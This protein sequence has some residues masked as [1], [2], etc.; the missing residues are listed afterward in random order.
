MNQRE[1]TRPVS[2]KTPQV[3]V[4]I[5]CFN[6]RSYLD[7]CLNSLLASD[8]SGLDR[9]LLVV[10]DGSTDGSADYVKEHFPGVYCIRTDPPNRGFAGVNNFGWDYIQEN[11]PGAEFVVLLNVDTIVESGWLT[12]LVDYLGEHPAVGSV[13]AKLRLHPQSETLNTAGNRCHFL[14]F[15]F[16]VGYGETDEGQYDQ[17]QSIDFASGAAVMVRAELLKQVGL[18]DDDFYM[19]LED[20]ELS[21]KLRQIGYDAHLVPESVVY[22][23][24][25]AN[26]PSRYY[27]LLERNR[28]ILLFTYYRAPTLLLLAPAFLFMELGQVAYA[29]CKGLVWGKLKSWGYFLKPRNLAWLWRRRQAA[30]VRRTAGDQEC[31]GRFCGTIQFEAVQNPL[32]TYVGN[33]ILGLYWLIVKRLIVW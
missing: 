31:M 24:Y 15:G 1:T 18:F 17:A 26:A 28:W 7:D 3:V 22:H 27:Y 5:S 11:F 29:A 13:Q 4:L 16:M 8:D 25:I 33:P 6:S 12:P 32:L 19:Y 10:D 14:G 23:K 21:W 30:Q 20:A 9:H 2:D